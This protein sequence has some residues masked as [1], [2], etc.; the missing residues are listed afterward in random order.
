MKRKIDQT[1]EPE[2]AATPTKK[3]SETKATWDN[4]GL[5][6]RL[7]QGVAQLNWHNPTDIQ[8]KAVPLALEGRDILAKSGTGTGKTAAYVLPV[9]EKV[10]QRK[11]KE[12]KGA[13]AATS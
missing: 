2:V 11:E 3:P 8:A 13:A 6:P 7:L 4:L 12:A 1:E 9:L 10:L 5:S